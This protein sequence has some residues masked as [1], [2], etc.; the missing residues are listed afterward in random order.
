M[1]VLHQSRCIFKAGCADLSSQAVKL[2]DG[3]A[4]YKEKVR[5]VSYSNQNVEA[6]CN[7]RV[8]FTELKDLLKG[9]EKLLG[10]RKWIIICT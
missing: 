2:S 8:K 7:S 3:W 10:S 6:T 4:K 9:V 5:D 1:S